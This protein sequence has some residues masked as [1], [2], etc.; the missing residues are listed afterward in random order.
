MQLLVLEELK[1]FLIISTRVC[2]RTEMALPRVVT[3]LLFSG[4]LLPTTLA[5]LCDC[6]FEWRNDWSPDISTGNCVR[7][8][9][10]QHHS[11]DT[12]GGVIEGGIARYICPNQ[13][14][15]EIQSRTMCEYNY[16]RMG[17]VVARVPNYRAGIGIPA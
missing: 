2:G 6:T 7:Q 10:I 15:P 9:R 14:F 12:S 3:A 1:N 8:K 11:G 17:I 5:G 16:L 13:C 4:Y